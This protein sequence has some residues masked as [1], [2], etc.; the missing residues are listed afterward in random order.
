MRFVDRV[1]RMDN[2]DTSPAARGT[3][4]NTNKPSSDVLK[5][6][7]MTFGIIGIM[8]AVLVIVGIDGVMSE[9]RR[10]DSIAY[11]ENGSELASAAE[12]A[13]VMASAELP[14]SEPDSFPMDINTA[15]KQDLMSVS[16]I[17]E[18]TADDITAFRESRGVITSIDQL[19]EIN[20]IGETMIALLKEY[21]YVSD[22]VYLPYTTTSVSVTSS[23]TETKA[24]KVTR[25]KTST[26]TRRDPS[27]R[28]TSQSPR[29][30]PPA[31]TEPSQNL[32]TE[33]ATEPDP[34]VS[35][36]VPVDINHASADE[37]SVCLLLPIEKAED[38]VAVRE[39]IQ[40][41][42]NVAELYLVGSLTKQDIIDITDY[43]VIVPL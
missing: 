39:Q 6:Y 22:D 5:R 37:I 14:C 12:A 11:H 16:G 31:D 21:F 27:A 3:E 15:D 33:T 42:S 17:G 32:D 23:V 24:T 25:E 7:R 36:R 28:R 13:E 43:I 35:E 29:T 1:D 9:T 41:F 38:I 18:K 10:N 2:K 8:L 19:A 26:R 30:E 4:T 34:S 40:Y 20:G